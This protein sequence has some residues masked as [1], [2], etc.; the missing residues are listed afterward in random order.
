[1]LLQSV[2][3]ELS[4]IIDENFQGLCNK[5][6]YSNR[7]PKKNH[8]Y[9][10]H[11]L[12]ACDPNLLCQSCRKHHNLFMMRG[13]T[14]DFLNVT[15]HVWEAMLQLDD[16][17]AKHFK[18]SKKQ[19]NQSCIGSLQASIAIGGRVALVITSVPVFSPALHVSERSSGTSQ[20]Q[21]NQLFMITPVEQ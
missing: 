11:K 3:R 9:I 13:C 20:S 10:G 6:N 8:P 7:T 4:F 15:T 19:K 18:E 2:K 16:L 21:I 1:M 12:L 17:D 14:K 5:A